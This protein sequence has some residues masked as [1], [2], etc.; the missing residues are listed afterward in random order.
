M[1][2]L[3]KEIGKRIA[4]QRKKLHISQNE[5]ATKLDKS[6]R[7][8]QKYESGEID[9]SISVLEQIAEILEISISD[10][11]GFDCPHIILES[12]ADVYDFFFELYR[13]EGI[14]Y[15]IYFER[16]PETIRKAHIIFDLHKSDYNV[17]MYN[18]LQKLKTNIHAYEN[19]FISY[20][21]LEDWETTEKSRARKHKLTDKEIEELDS[22]T[23]YKKRDEAYQRIFEEQLEQKRRKRQKAIEEGR[24]DEL[25]IFDKYDPAFDNDYDGSNEDDSGDSGQ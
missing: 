15:D 16:G 18:L 12:M 17:D 22:M 1:D 25:D 14:F 2:D 9:M 3:Q 10:L 20:S 7:T 21:T 19:F 13:K 4:A 6:L 11:I 23:F 24:L 8:V 5:L